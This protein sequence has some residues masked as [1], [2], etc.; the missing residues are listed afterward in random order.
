[1]HVYTVR[2]PDGSVLATLYLS[3][4][5]KRNSEKAPRGFTLAPAFKFRAEDGESPHGP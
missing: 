3:P 1:M 5:H 4:Y 2:H